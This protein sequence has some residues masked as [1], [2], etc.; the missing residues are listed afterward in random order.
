M[1]S[2]ELQRICRDLTQ[3]GESVVICCTKE[4]VKF[5]ANGDLGTGKLLCL[6]LL[7]WAKVYRDESA[8]FV[9]PLQIW[10]PF[11]RYV[12]LVNRRKFIRGVRFV[13]SFVRGDLTRFTGDMR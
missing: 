4:G 13:L 3:I 5:S 7:V 6:W 9:S 1:P 12:L 11:I 8:L 10:Q 2:A